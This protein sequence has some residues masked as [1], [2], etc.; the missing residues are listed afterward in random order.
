MVPRDPHAEDPHDLDPQPRPL[1]ARGLLES[2]LVGM[3]ADRTDISDSSEYALELRQ[4]ASLR[5]AEQ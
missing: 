5:S 2:E 1:T 3:W 4:Q